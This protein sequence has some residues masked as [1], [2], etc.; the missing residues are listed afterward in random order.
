MDKSEKRKR[1]AY[2]V[3]RGNGKLHNKK[4]GGGVEV[5]SGEYE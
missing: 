1:K 3:E 2:G 4:K 5:E